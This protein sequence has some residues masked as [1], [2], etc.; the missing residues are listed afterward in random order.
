VD[1]W[2]ELYDVYDKVK[3]HTY[4]GEYD[5]QADLFRVFNLVHDGHFRFSPDLLTTPISFSRSVGLVSVSL[6]GRDLPQVYVHC[7]HP[8][9]LVKIVL[10]NQPISR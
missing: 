5:F 8:Y 4:A 3:N 9:P 6:N 10:T 1:I 2:A 7:M